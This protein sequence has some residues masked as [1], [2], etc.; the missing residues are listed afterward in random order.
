MDPP[1]VHIQIPAPRTRKRTKRTNKGKLM[2]VS[3][4]TGPRTSN[5]R[6]RKLADGRIGQQRNKQLT[7][8]VPAVTENLDL[9]DKADGGAPADRDDEMGQNTSVAND[10]PPGETSEKRPRRKSVPD[11]WAVRGYHYE[12]L[13]V[14]H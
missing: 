7:H 5:Y 10:A 14:I 11:T 3:D 12:W 13:F 2:N 6:I 9:R 4:S 8:L 1:P